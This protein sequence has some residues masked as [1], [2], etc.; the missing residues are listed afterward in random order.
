[1][2]SPLVPHQFVFSGPALS[3]P[4]ILVVITARVVAV[5]VVAARIVAD[6]VFAAHPVDAHVLT[7]YIVSA[8]VVSTHVANK[9]QTLHCNL[10]LAFP[11]SRDV[12]PSRASKMATSAE[13]KNIV[14]AESGSTFD[15][16]R[17]EKRLCCMAD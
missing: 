13:D 4:A 17:E 16:I 3:L 12:S 9:F 14:L 11:D 10:D 6:H 5:L 15:I 7:A 2:S 8:H 1:M